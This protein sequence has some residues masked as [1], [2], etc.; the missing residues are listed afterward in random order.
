L[1]NQLDWRFD[2]VPPSGAL[3]G[4]A[5]ETFVFKPR[6]SAF[7]REVLQN[8]HDQ[9][10][11]GQ[12]ARVS[13]RLH[14]Y[15]PGSEARARVERHLR[16]DVFDEHLSAV[17]T[18]DDTMGLRVRRARTGLD[19]RPLVALEISDDNTRGLVGGEQTRGENFAGLCR[20]VLDTPPGRS[21]GRG[22]SYGLGKAVLWLYSSFSTIM[23]YSRL[24]EPDAG[25]STRFIGRTVLPYHETASNRYA[26]LGWLGAPAV[27]PAGE[28]AESVWDERADEI[29][30]AFGITRAGMTSGTSILVIGFREPY[31]DTDRSLDEVARDIVAHATRWFWPAILAPEPTLAVSSAVVRDGT[32]GPVHHAGSAAE[33]AGFVNARSATDV[34]PTAPSSGDIAER[35]IPFTVPALR[36]PKGDQLSGEVIAQFRLRVLRSDDP[37]AELANSVALMRGTGMVVD[38][39]TNWARRPSDGQPYFAVLE[40]GR[41]HGLEKHDDAAEDFLRACEPP[42]HDEWT[43]TDAAKERYVPGIQRS[44]DELAGRVSS[45]IAEI[46]EERPSSGQTGPAMLAK[47]F[48]LSS[49]GTGPGPRGPQFQET[50]DG[51]VL[52]GTWV[53]RGV[54]KRVRGDG[55]WESSVALQLDVESG[56]P[57]PIGLASCTAASDGVSFPVLD[58]EESA[59]V[60]IPAH[61]DTFEFVAV[62][63][64]LV[65]DL[66]RT[67]LVVKVQSRLASV[68]DDEVPA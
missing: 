39:R 29:A 12:C 38:Y 30:G 19:A 35:S 23:F 57:E 1:K 44:L 65:D 63:V 17:A 45:A 18:G 60:T 40:A 3:T 28:Y 4:G 11:S 61:I 24:S 37:D 47:L 41:A 10:L 62:S 58:R 31:L 49:R 27:T 5:A 42:A 33:V 32:E 52:D 51:E 8:S 56:R 55:P 34:R 13:F 36:D 9:R 16:W 25:R 22:G 50:L 6:L 15:L 48:P 2:P 53:V 54:V 21:P 14:E 64:P 46:C 20:H 66:L 67:R 43:I 59:L 7:I 68:L 26:G